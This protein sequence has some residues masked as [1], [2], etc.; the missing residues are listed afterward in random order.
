MPCDRY[1]DQ[2]RPILGA[3]AN[4]P[5]EST[6][7]L[8]INT[9]RFR[10]ENGQG[11][12]FFD[13]GN[14]THS[15]VRAHP[16][17]CRSRHASHQSSHLSASAGASSCSMC[18]LCQCS[19]ATVSCR[20]LGLSEIPCYFPPETEHMFEFVSSPDL[21]SSDLSGNLFTEEILIQHADK[22]GGL[23]PQ[24]VSLYDIDL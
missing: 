21:T 13:H 2:A 4:H 23:I 24:L 6:A 20:N 14:Q 17:P 16:P 10:L 22:F 11:A 15:C 5:L 8:A 9:L 18:D 1:P 12:I 19:S 3:V 7:Y